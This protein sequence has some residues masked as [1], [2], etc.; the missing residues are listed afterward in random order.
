MSYQQTA[1]ITDSTCDIPSDL[2]ERYQIIVLPH[3]LIWNEEQYRD[4]VD[5]QPEAFYRRLKTEKQ[6]P[7]TAQAS[8]LDFATAFQQVQEQGAAEAVVLT[9]SGHFSGAIR[10]AL[11][12]AQQSSIDVH[13]VDLKGVTMSLGW[14]V[15]AAA[16]AREAGANAREMLAAA[17]K[18]RDNVQL[19]ISLDTLEYLYR[20]G[21]IGN[22]RRLIGAMLNIKPLI[23]VDHAT[24][25]VEPGGM[26]P[27]RKR[28]IDQMYRKFFAQFNDKSNLHVAV[29]HGGAPQDAAALVE[30]VQ[31]EFQPVELLTNITCPALG[32]NTGPQALALA[33]YAG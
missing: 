10:S 14:Q 29:L 31:R 17:Q 19:Y 20:G 25:I 5:L 1:L 2:L 7:T 24:G 18:V 13:V 16:R 26:S 4:R 3:V 21:R 8:I 33:G 6:L 12:A 32:L 23:Y 30:R 11:Q 28:A 27:T 9:L 22:A 15:L